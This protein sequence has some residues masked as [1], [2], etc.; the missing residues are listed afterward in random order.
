[1]EEN[2]IVEF[3]KE[4]G[5][6]MVTL[7]FGLWFAHK[8]TYK[9]M[10][11]KSAVELEQ[12]AKLASEKRK[13]ETVYLDLFKQYIAFFKDKLDESDRRCEERL[14]YVVERH[15]KDMAILRDDYTT[16]REA[17]DALA[18]VKTADATTNNE[19]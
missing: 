6:A 4:Q 10:S 8:F 5:A 9:I 13:A 14:R 7:V 16:L 15:A 19:A 17:Y 11:D 3:I 2:I 12:N 18:L 1:M